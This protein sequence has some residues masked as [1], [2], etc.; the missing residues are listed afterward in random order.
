MIYEIAKYKKPWLYF[1]MTNTEGFS[2]NNLI[3][4]SSKNLSVKITLK[5]NK[6]ILIS[7]IM[8]F[9]FFNLF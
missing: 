3:T 6:K 8:F 1:D 2:S 7:D 5:T 4:N 9:M